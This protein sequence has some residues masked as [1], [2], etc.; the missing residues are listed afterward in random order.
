MRAP[1]AALLAGLALAGCGMIDSSPGASG[2][3][4]TALGPPG[5]RR[6]E[7]R[8]DGTIV[9][10]RELPVRPIRAN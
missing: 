3:P 10:D 1:L 8:T 2:F 9:L 6:G 5:F 4:D 7:M